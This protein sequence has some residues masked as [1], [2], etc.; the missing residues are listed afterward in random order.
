MRSHLVAEPPPLSNKVWDRLRHVI[1]EAASSTSPVELLLDS[2]RRL[3]EP[4]EVEQ[5]EARL[6]ALS[7]VEDALAKLRRLGIGVLS[8]FD[9]DY[10]RRFHVTL[11]SKEPSLL[12][13]AGNPE[14]LNRPSIGIVGSRDADQAAQAFARS[15]AEAAVEKGYAVVSGGA[16]GIDQVS[17]KAAYD[18][19]GDSIGFLAESLV[20]RAAKEP[21][22][23]EGGRVCLAT[24]YSPDAPFS[25]GNAMG[26]NKLIYG[27]AAATVVV[28]AASSSGG[29]WAGA[30]EA[31][32]L[33]LPVLVR[34][35]PGAPDGN[36]DLMQETRGDLFAQNPRALEDPEKLWELIQELH[37]QP[38]R[39]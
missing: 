32:R 8:E 14:L 3:L 33:N 11:G 16:K 17:M 35:G 27:H 25:V 2:A 31:I 7:S 5:V 38:P 9:E 15:V 19:G 1:P 28:S 34:S 39:V 6:G 23:I 24:P 18:A 21:E 26:R 30:V 36:K 12:F 29:T 37:P 10:P 13:F 20:R 22:V 4:G